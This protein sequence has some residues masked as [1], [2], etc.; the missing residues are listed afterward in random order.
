[1]KVTNFAQ[2]QIFGNGQSDAH[3][4]ESSTGLA[5]ENTRSI[6]RIAASEVDRPLC[7]PPVRLA[8]TLNSCGFAA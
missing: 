8:P 5:F 7:H 2:R 3:H 6:L 1:M 4:S